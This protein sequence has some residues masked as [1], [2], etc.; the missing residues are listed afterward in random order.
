MI[1]ALHCHKGKFKFDM[2]IKAEQ[3]IDYFETNE[4]VWIDVLRENTEEIEKIVKVLF[5]EHYMLILEDCTKG[6]RPKL[7][8]YEKF[9]FMVFKTY[10]KAKQKQLGIIFGQNIIIT[11]REKEQSFSELLESVTKLGTVH[12]DFILYRI[13]DDVFEDYDKIIDHAEVDAQEYEATAIS[14]PSPDNLKSITMLKRELIDLH[15][16]L[17]HEKEII[18]ILVKTN[19]KYIKPKTKIFFRDVHDDIL[20]IID[21]EKTLREVLSSS[22]T[23][24]MSSVNNSLNEVMKL[25]TVISAFVMVPTLIGAI[26]GMNFEYM[27]ELKSIY[28]YPFALLLMITSV[29]IMY[30]FFKRKGWV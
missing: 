3:A 28:G 19:N 14:K 4:Q 30:I 9:M 25:L 20:H 23:V 12:A 11:I 24:H 6:S 1:S 22:I 10:P 27:P 16:I 21:N 8:F 15:N 5:P 17:V 26:Y 7:E 29:S 2:D 13:L 18:N